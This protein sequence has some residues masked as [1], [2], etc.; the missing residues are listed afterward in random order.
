M[1]AAADLLKTACEEAYDQNKESCSHAVWYVLK[2]IVNAKE[3]WRQANSLITHIKGGSWYSVTLDNGLILADKGLVVVGGLTDEPNGHVIVIYPGS[4]KLNGG[5]QF[6]SK[7]TGKLETLQGKAQYPL[8][9]STSSGQWPGAKSRG[10]RTVW[11]PWGS[12]AK[13]AMVG[14]WTPCLTLYVNAAAAVA[15]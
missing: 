11:D 6:M 14:F 1:A 13:F 2:K 10:T 4:K 15:T 5:Y 9:L 8:C 7:K 3:P 12:N